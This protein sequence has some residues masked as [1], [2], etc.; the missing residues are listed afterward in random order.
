MLV[1]TGCNKPAAGP[2]ASAD[3]IKVGEFASLTGSEATFGQ[4]SHH[5]TQL[6]VDQLNAAGGVLGKKSNCSPRT[7]SRRPASL[8]QWCAN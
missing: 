3:I 8:P 5:G 7:I 2:D 1:L 4:S 6:A